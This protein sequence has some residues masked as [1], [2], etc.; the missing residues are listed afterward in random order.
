MPK[1]GFPV[2]AEITHILATNI[3]EQFFFVKAD[4]LTQLK[5]LAD[6]FFNRNWRQNHDCDYHLTDFF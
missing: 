5:S 4:F 2:M 6:N 3:P 1:G